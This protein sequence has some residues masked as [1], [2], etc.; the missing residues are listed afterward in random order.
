YPDSKTVFTDGVCFKNEHSNPEKSLEM[1][2][3]CDV[4]IACM[5]EHA[6]ESGEATSKT[7]LE[8]PQDQREYLDGLFALG[9]PVVLLV[10]AGRPLILTDY[11]GRAAAILYIWDPGTECGNAVCDVLTGAYNPAGKTT[12]SFPRRSG[13]CP[14]YYNHKPTGRP[15]VKGLLNRTFE[16]KYIDCPVGALYPFGY[17]KSY[18][19]FGYSDASISSGEMK[20]GGSVTVSC[21]I[22]N[23]G[24]YPGEEIAQLY[25]RDVVASITRPVCELKGFEKIYLKPGESRTVSFTLT[26]SDL[27]FWNA[28]MVYKAERGKFRCR[29]AP[30]SYADADEFEFTLK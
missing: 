7:S 20:K 13:Q 24:K 18:T 28:D 12:V 9:V 10:S 16:S 2:K 23:T 8:L 17:G 1:L 22:T 21:K 26:P 15:T 25:V 4:I 14:I 6:R 11:V 29:I 5:G 19:T 3:G 30:D 27:A